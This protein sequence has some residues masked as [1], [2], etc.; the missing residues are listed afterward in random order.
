MS[1]LEMRLYFVGSAMSLLGRPSW[2]RPSAVMPERRLTCPILGVMINTA[3]NTAYP[4]LEKP[5]QLTQRASRRARPL[6]PSPPLRASRATGSQRD[7][8]VWPPVVA[9]RRRVSRVTAHTQTA[10][11]RRALR[12][13]MARGCSQAHR[14]RGRHGVVGATRRVCPQRLKDRGDLY[15][16]RLFAE[17]RD[18]AFQK[19]T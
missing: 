5:D 18:C 1:P 2:S 3:A 6:P 14:G 7:S 12:M 9:K 11:A 10:C 4:P 15:R 17:S 19:G 13:G 8:P 16:Q